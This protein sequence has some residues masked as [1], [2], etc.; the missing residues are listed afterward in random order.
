MVLYNKWNVIEWYKCK[1]EK[2]FKEK[3]IGDEFLDF[4]S[5]Y[6]VVDFRCEN[7][8]DFNDL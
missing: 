2:E 6:N 7:D 5:L 1:F 4:I 3:L 8:E